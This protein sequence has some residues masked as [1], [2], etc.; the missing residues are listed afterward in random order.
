MPIYLRL[1]G[2]STDPAAFN[3]SL[4]QSQRPDYTALCNQAFDQ[5]TFHTKLKAT[6]MASSASQVPS[7]A[8]TKPAPASL[9]G[10]PVEMQLQII[11][12]V[13]N[14]SSGSL[15]APSP[16]LS[17]NKT[18]SRSSKTADR[19]NAAPSVRDSPVASNKRSATKA[20]SQPADTTAL[21]PVALLLA[22]KAMYE[23]T[24][25]VLL[26]TKTTVFNSPKAFEDFWRHHKKQGTHEFIRSVTFDLR[27]ARSLRDYA[28]PM[29]KLGFKES[30]V[31][32]IELLMGGHRDHP[33]ADI[34]HVVDRADILSDFKALLPLLP[35]K[36]QRISARIPEY[37]RQLQSTLNDITC[38]ACMSPS[39]Y[40]DHGDADPR[41]PGH[42]CDP[43]LTSAAFEQL[44][45]D[46]EH[47]LIQYSGSYEI[48][49]LAPGPVGT[50]YLMLND[51]YTSQMEYLEWKAQ[52]LF[53]ELLA[54]LWKRVLD[55]ESSAVLSETIDLPVAM[56]SDDAR[57][58]PLLGRWWN[59]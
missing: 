34:R 42:T 27:T 14:S 58:V 55:G 28:M 41:A 29:I 33:D 38:R 12:D 46:Q 25:E 24:L 4:S 39:F 6:N 8:G 2:E 40:T 30:E 31:Q 52:C 18:A 26:T 15:V 3:N 48:G 54:K 43:S 37:E 44:S 32:N 1:P 17:A 16:K 51:L 19:G 13:C 7:L 47:A 5:Q 56:S 53:N 49:T 59:I 21:G 57:I 36:L 50:G 22:S 35:K 11:R 9:L 10:L 20:G 23:P 45:D